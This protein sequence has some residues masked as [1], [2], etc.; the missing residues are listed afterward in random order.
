MYRLLPALLPAL[1]C[2]IAGGATAAPLRVGGFVVA[3]LVLGEPDKPLRG[4]LRDFL[5]REVV[6]GGVAMR[7]M[8][9][10]S[11]PD[12]IAALREGTLDI[13]LVASGQ[14]ARQ[15]G[16]AT[17]S[18]T[19]LYTRPNL[20]VREDFPLRTVRSLDQL[21]GM[22]IGWVAGAALSPRLKEAGATWRR[23]AG[24]TWQ[25]ENL[26]LVQAG[27]IDGAY[28]ENEYSPRYL[29][30]VGGMPLRVVRL[31][32]P[33]R[34]VFML[35]SLK[36]DKA[37]IARFDRVAGEAFAGS[38]FRDFLERYTASGVPRPR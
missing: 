18:F 35:Y 15:A 26:R 2:T 3:P 11:L 13:V 33:P 31:P 20:A 37:D 32:M 38:R 19:Y 27:E 17:S 22:R 34:A 28:F 14:A 29:A 1:L 24:H 9:T 4:A 6:P 21:A 7:W 8:S 10:S 30:H 16:T 36:A 5:E 25:L 12:G 23:A